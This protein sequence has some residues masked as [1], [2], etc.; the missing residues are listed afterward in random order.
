M[1]YCLS[2]NNKARRVRGPLRPQAIRRDFDELM[3][4]IRTVTALVATLLRFIV[5]MATWAGG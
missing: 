5:R 2:S 4:W 1:R 3:H